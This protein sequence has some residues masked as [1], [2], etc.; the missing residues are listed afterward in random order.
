MNTNISCESCYSL[1]IMRNSF[2]LYTRDTSFYKQSASI[3]HFCFLT[4]TY[5]NSAGSS[6]TNININILCESCYWLYIMQN[7][8]TFYMLDMNLYKQRACISH[9]CF[10]N[11]TYPNSAGST[12]RN[13]NKIISCESCYCVCIMRT[14]HEK[15]VFVNRVPASR[16]VASSPVHTQT[17]RVVAIQI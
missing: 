8:D 11:I 2:A 7:S 5:S 3:S 17:Q 12:Y 10:F 13:I 9:S 1:C 16:T 15:W 14:T 4:I 6:Y